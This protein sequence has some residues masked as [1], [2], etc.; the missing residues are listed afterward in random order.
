VAQLSTDFTIPSAVSIDEW[1]EH[2]EKGGNTG[3]R[4]SRR[5]D[6]FEDDET[7]PSPTQNGHGNGHTQLF[8]DRPD[9]SQS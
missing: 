1:L 9:R 7:E 3:G 8:S 5:I 2:P 6:E 4:N